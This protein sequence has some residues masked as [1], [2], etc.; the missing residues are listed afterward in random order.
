MK[1]ATRTRL[2]VVLGT[3]G[4]K[5]EPLSKNWSVPKCFRA[6]LAATVLPL[7]I[8]VQACNAP[9]V[10]SGTASVNEDTL[11]PSA[12]ETDYDALTQALIGSA[13]RRAEMGVHTTQ[14]LEAHKS[15]TSNKLMICGSYFIRED[16][17]QRSR[18]FLSTSG[19]LMLID[20]PNDSRWKMNCL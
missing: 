15:K 9:S 2:N 18:Y 11:P 6:T 17:T 14:L 13:L 3:A 7:S 5:I 1:Y 12:P 4:A 10:A 20:T 8:S 16:S 19:T